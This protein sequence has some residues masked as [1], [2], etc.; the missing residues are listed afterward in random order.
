MPFEADDAA[1]GGALEHAVVAGGEVVGH[2]DR[3]F[4]RDGTGGALE[5]AFEG[6]QAPGQLGAVG[7]QPLVELTQRLDAQA[8]EAALGIAADLDQ[9]G[10][11]QHLEVPGHP[12]LVH[13]DGVDE[14]GHRTLTAPHRVEDPSAGR[15]GDHLEDGTGGGH[16][17]K[18]TASRIYEQA[19]LPGVVPWVE[20]CASAA[21]FTHV[22]DGC[23]PEG[24]GLA[25]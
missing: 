8:V 12:G 7:L 4:G 20:H 11:A 17:D 1:V 14:L 3:S 22:P 2:W 18:H 19:D 5:V 16:D 6:V 21:A 25:R 13:A 15:V 9:A 10:V 24:Q 23:G